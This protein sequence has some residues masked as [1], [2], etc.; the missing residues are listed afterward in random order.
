[1]YRIKLPAISSAV[2]TL[3]DDTDKDNSRHSLL[4][5]SFVKVGSEN[6]LLALLH[7]ILDITMGMINFFFRSENFFPMIFLTV[8]ILEQLWISRLEKKRCTWPSERTWVKSQ[9]LLKKE[10]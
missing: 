10:V 4:S 1:M 9:I 6:P 7:K 5:C 2:D 3:F 8:S